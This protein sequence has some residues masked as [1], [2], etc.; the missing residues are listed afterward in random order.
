MQ[1]L[2]EV[3]WESDRVLRKGK[4]KC[5]LQSS[6][7][8]FFTCHTVLLVTNP[9]FTFFPGSSLPKWE[10]ALSLITGHLVTDAKPKLS[11]FSEAIFPMLRE[12]LKL[13][14]DHAWP[15]RRDQNPFSGCHIRQELQFH[16]EFRLLKAESPLQFS[17]VGWRHLL[18]SE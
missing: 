8:Q 10:P 14:Q 15:L 11:L 7:P 2:P 4:T 9:G 16:S 6:S 12:A 17:R 18:S 13:Y 5:L 3:W 1:L